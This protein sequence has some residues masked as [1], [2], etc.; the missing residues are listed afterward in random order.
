[1]EVAQF[2]LNTFHIVHS[3]V[4]RTTPDCHHQ[5]ISMGMHSRRE[6]IVSHEIFIDVKISCKESQELDLSVFNGNELT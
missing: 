6:Y 2:K 4:C 3:R 1:M 5:G